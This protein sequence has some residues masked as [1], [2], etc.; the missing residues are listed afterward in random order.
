MRA[1][2]HFLL[3][4]LLIG[5]GAGCASEKKSSKPLS[6]MRMNERISR[7]V[8]AMK[9]GMDKN[10]PRYQSRY[11][12]AMDASIAKKNGTA[13]W[14]SRK[15]SRTRTL[16]HLETFRA[17]EFSTREFAQADARSPLGT[18]NAR[19]ATSR[20]PLADQAFETSDSRLAG[21]VSRDAS[22]QARE[23][24]QTF[25]TQEDVRGRNALRSS[26]PPEFIVL[27]EQVKSPAYT[28]DQVRRLLGRD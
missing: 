12:K 22:L 26:K 20:S 11:Q 7:S 4:P 25:R 24:G 13:G 2:P 27:P 5:L 14:L 10:D 18:R 28:E 16:E 9:E 23:A 8:R 19:E 1:R 3:L 21:Q 15:Q 17:G 6:E